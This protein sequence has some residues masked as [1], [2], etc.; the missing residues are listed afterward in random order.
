MI[1][2]DENTVCHFRM[3]RC[4]PQLKLITSSVQV[5]LTEADLCLN[6]GR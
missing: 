6:M 3:M 4:T 2:T 1:K 5:V